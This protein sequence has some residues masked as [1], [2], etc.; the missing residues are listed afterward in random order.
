MA[1]VPEGQVLHLAMDA[2]MMAC[3][4]SKRRAVR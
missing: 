3:T 2:K 1:E 4:A